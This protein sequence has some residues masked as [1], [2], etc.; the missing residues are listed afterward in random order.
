MSDSTL[1]VDGC[2]T[3]GWQIRGFPNQGECVRAF[4]A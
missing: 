4:A 3:G 2:T 1:T